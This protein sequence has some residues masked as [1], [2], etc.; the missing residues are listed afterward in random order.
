MFALRTRV[1]KSA[2]G[3]V[4]TIKFA[5]LYFIGLPAS[6]F[7]PRNLTFVGKISKANTA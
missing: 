1:K 7:H 2:I 6:L 3:S 5:L 4:M